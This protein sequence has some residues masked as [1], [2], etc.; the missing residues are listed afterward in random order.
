MRG[1]VV[2][3]R[4]EDF[5]ADP[6]ELFFDLAYV[7]AFSQLVGRLIHEP[8]WTGV[9]K[10]ALLFGLLWIPWQQLTWSANAVSGNGRAVRLIFLV[11]TVASVPM[12][13]ATT[14]ALG[15]GGPVFAVALGVI[16]GLGFLTQTLGADRG[17]TFQ[18]AVLRWVGPNIAALVVLLIG[19][20]VEGQGRIAL[21]LLSLAVVFGAMVA[22]G[23]GEWIVR[24]GHFAERHG[25]IVIIALGEVIVAIGLPV[26]EGLEAGEG[27]PG[28]TVV[29]LLASGTFAALLWWGYF[30]RPG[31]ALE[32]R[33]EL[34]ESDAERG[35]YVRDVYTWA[36]A[37]LVAGIILSAAA[38]EEIT[39]HPADDVELAFRTM[40][41][42]GLGLGVIGIGAAI[43]RAFH[44]VVRERIVAATVIA[45]VLLLG[46]SIDGV[47]LLLAVD[48][49]IAATLA[50]E[51]SRIER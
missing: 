23:R 22:A 30:D 39:L 33:A 36:H 35:R 7:F 18:R 38:L 13:A 21:W 24:S 15:S 34:L 12:A 27:L 40:L 44:A 46:G 4:T 31:P 50:V 45:V 3:E 25:L 14:T 2:P 29:A 19:A 47:V 49:I 26:L 9:G 48:L 16:M 51:H 37:P 43:W 28:R 41:F 32:H 42:G 11:A 6:V 8:T 10:V 5:T 17:S 20:F 1:I